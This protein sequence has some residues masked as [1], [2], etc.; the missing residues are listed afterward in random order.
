[1]N[2]ESIKLSEISKSEKEN[3]VLYCLHEVHAI[4]KITETECAIE[5]AG[6]GKR[7]DGKLSL[8]SKGFVW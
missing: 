3:T 8:K 7:G 2:F 1:M 5:D 6:A 4:G